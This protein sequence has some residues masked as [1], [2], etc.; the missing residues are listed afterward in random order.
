MVGPTSRG[1]VMGVAEEARDAGRFNA[2]VDGIRYGTKEMNAAAW[3]IF[4]DIISVPTVDDLRDCLQLLKT[5]KT[6]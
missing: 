1:A 5:L 4:N 3:G 6:Y 2:I